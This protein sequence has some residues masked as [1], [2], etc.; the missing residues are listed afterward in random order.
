MVLHREGAPRPFARRSLLGLLALSVVVGLALLVSGCTESEGPVT[1]TDVSL[2]SVRVLQPVVSSDSTQTLDEYGLFY[3][4]DRDDVVALDSNPGY[5][6]FDNDAVIITDP[7]VKQVRVL[8]S[9]VSYAN[10]SGLLSVDA[11]KLTPGTT[12]YYRVYTIGHDVNGIVWRTLFTVGSHTTSNPTLKSLKK[13]AGTLA[14]SFSNMKFSYTCT[15]SKS[16]PSTKI[17]VVPTLSG[18]S[19][20][21]SLGGT[22][23][24][25]GRSKVVSVAKGHNKTLSIRVIAPDGYGV[26]YAVKVVRKK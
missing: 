20:S 15:I 6:G 12:Y 18:S 13:S 17:T 2:G 9:Y 5:D 8:R 23:W 21:M 16:T 3:S 7:A 26:V 24:A 10:Q 25:A 22:P 14:P 1:Y 4:T 19:V 11:K